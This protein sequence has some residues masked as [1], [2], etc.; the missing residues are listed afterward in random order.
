MRFSEALDSLAATDIPG[1]FTATVSDDWLQGRSVF[2]G[3]QAALAVRAMREVMPDAPM[4]R[5]LQTTFIAPV[6]AGTIRIE[7]KVLRVGKSAIHA[8][9]R[10]FDGEQLACLV[11]AV[12]GASRPSTITIDLPPI[13][14]PAL[15]TARRL[16]YVAGI[17]PAFLQHMKLSWAL[18]AWPF[19][20]GSE[21]R[22][23]VWVAVAG[24]PVITEAVAIALADVIPSPALSTFKKPT[25]ASSLTWTL[26]FLGRPLD[27][28]QAPWLMDAEVT[29]GRDGYLAQTATLADEHGRPVA[30]SRQ[31]VVVFG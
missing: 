9:A 14:A 16:P 27:V 30:L 25:V 11:I 12:F 29:A 21:A 5:T 8:E 28:P 31:S 6:P 19:G 18:G 22:T 26:E 7:A 2:G 3:L 24:E 17:A 20:G 13:S 10:L 4:L 1:Q 23:Q 15:E